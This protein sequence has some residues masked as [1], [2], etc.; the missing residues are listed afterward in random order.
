MGESVR[1][2]KITERTSD[3]MF[4]DSKSNEGFAR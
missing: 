4:C 2:E 1:W 3:V